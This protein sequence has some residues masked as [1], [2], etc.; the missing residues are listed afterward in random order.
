[1]GRWIILANQDKSKVKIRFLEL[2][3]LKLNRNREVKIKIKANRLKILTLTIRFK[4]WILY[5]LIIII[6]I[7]KL[8][9]FNQI[10][11]NQKAFMEVILFF[12][13]KNINEK[14][15]KKDKET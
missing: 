10:N 3:K 11:N 4:M 8:K 14:N 2:K 1:M 7:H 9:S 6:K 5:K 12:Q 13:L 15:V